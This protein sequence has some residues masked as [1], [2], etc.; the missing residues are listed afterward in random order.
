MQKGGTTELLGDLNM[1][2]IHASRLPTVIN[3]IGKLR[4]Y[5]SAM[6]HIPNL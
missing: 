1:C 6:Q 5:Y 2:L 4:I 3:P